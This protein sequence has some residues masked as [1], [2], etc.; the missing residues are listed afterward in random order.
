VG[1][2]IYYSPFFAF[3]K[4]SQP[5]NT[6]PYGS[7]DPV[8]DPDWSTIFYLLVNPTVAASVVVPST[9]TTA[10][11]RDY[12]DNLQ[13]WAT[14]PG[15]LWLFPSA[16]GSPSASNPGFTYNAA[17]QTLGFGGVMSPGV[18]SAL[19]GPLEVVQ[20]NANGQPVVQNGHLLLDP[21]TFVAASSL[22]A[23]YQASQGSAPEPAPGLQIGG[24]GLFK[25]NA[26]SMDL[27]NSQGIESWGIVGPLIS[28]SAVGNNYVSL[29]SLTTAG[30][31]VDVTVNSDL[32]MLT[33]RIASMYGGD[34][35]VD[36]G[37]TM[38]LG[39][40]GI[41]SQANDN[42]YGIYTTGHSDVSVTSVGDININGSR[43]AAF[44]GGTVTVESTAGSVDVG[45]GANTYVTVPLVSAVAA[46]QFT[47]IGDGNGDFSYYLG[48]QI[49]GSGV[50]A[51]SLPKSIQ[52]S[53]EPPLP[54]NITIET[55]NGNI[56]SSDAGVLQ[57]ALDGSTAAGPIIT[58]EAG[59][60]GVAATTSQG[61]VD[62]G[63][64]GVI[65]GTVDITA[66]GNVSGLVISRQN[67]VINTVG[68]FSGTLLAA[69]T[70][71][72][73]AGG[74]VSGTIIGVGGINASA[75]SITAT[76]LSQNV[77]GGTSALTTSATA[78]T[79]SQAAAT[80]SSNDT[81]QE[82]ATTG[83]T[84]EE[85]KKKK[86]PQ[87]LMQKTKRVTVILPKS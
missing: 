69:G 39:T 24:P 18:Y 52:A 65:G 61:N 38:D 54:G 10:Q 26:G 4:L 35:T 41:A 60:P 75:G 12:I 63:H 29:V 47:K 36:A 27:G 32:T 6:V 62:L 57:Y 5:I 77:S 8:T 15:P 82:V 74:S 51:T 33:S 22:T 87:P 14:V 68:S 25:I 48:Y 3:E 53:G 20:L 1:G 44:N 79:T 16:S 81:K 58:I 55:P 71:D 11:L 73:S 50:V 67:S 64:S 19:T 78:T 34:I 83:N 28:S 42:A 37:G 7:D 72:I 86:K 66:Q 49:Y 30:A 17:T 84:D 43:I 59:T 13:N 76:L 45:S 80:V 85:E 56:S 31:N 23:L 21:V 70:A 46:P 9:A 2:Q 40:Q